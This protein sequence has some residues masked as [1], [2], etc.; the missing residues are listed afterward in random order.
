MQQ[1][2]QQYWFMY[3]WV[4]LVLCIRAQI[5]SLYVVAQGLVFSSRGHLLWRFAR[6]CSWSR[7]VVSSSSAFWRSTTLHVA[8]RSCLLLLCYSS[9]PAGEVAPNRS[10]PALLQRAWPSPAAAA[11]LSVVRPKYC[12]HLPATFRVIFFIIATPHSCCWHWNKKRAS[13]LIIIKLAITVGRS[14]F[15]CD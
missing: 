15:F 5:L 8:V 3:R 2:Q 10:L 6:T 1:P 9:V 11:A 4:L 12:R 7:P 13:Y 14:F